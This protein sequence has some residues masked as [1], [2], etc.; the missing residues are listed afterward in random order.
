M[1]FQPAQPLLEIELPAFKRAAE[2]LVARLEL[3]KN[4]GLALLE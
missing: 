1:V 4:S 3:L 2:P